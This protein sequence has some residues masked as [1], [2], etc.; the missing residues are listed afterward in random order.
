[1]GLSELVRARVHAVHR[2]GMEILF[3]GSAVLGQLS[4]S[5]PSMLTGIYLRPQKPAP[6]TF[7]LVFISEHTVPR[8]HDLVFELAL[9]LRWRV[10]KERERTDRD[11]SVRG[12]TT[13][14]FLHGTFG[15]ALKKV[16]AVALV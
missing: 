4:G 10:E 8:L 11:E 2:R 12:K 9:S 5:C 6:V 16:P 14:N 13:V 3:L 15:V 7:L 1:M